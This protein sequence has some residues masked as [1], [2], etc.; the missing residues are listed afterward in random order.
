[1]C[2]F[3]SNCFFFVKDGLAEAVRRTRLHFVHC[4]LPSEGPGGAGGNE[5]G[6]DTPTFNVALVRSQLRGSQILDAVRVRKQG[7]S[8]LH[9]SG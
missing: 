5:D 1:M 4:L 7:E 9:V 6:G 8:H 3:F 2:E